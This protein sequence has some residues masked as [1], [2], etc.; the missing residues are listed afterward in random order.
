MQIFEISGGLNFLGKKG[1]LSTSSFFRS[2]VSIAIIQT[3]GLGTQT[4]VHI[5]VIIHLLFMVKNR[6]LENG[7]LTLILIHYLN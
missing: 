6:D 5:Q 1:F 7:A 2:G 3:A 4:G